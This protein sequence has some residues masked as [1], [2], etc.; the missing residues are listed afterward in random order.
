MLLVHGTIGNP[1][2]KRI[3]GTLTIS[4]HDD[5]FPPVQWPVSDSHF[6]ALIYMM[7]GANRVKFDFSS[8]KLTNSGTSNPLHTSY[9]TIHMVHNSNAPPVHLAIMMGK[10]SPGTFDAVPARIER[11]GNGLET[12]VRKF[13][14]AAYLW[15]AYTTEQ[16][17]RNSFGRRCFRFDEEWTQGTSNYRDREM[18]T[19]RSE[20]RIHIV[21]C[22]K[23]VEELRNL[24]RTGQNGELFGIGIE[25]MKNYFQPKDGQKLYVSCLI[26]DSH[27]DPQ[28]KDILAHAALG[29]GAGDISL[30]IF[31]SHCL[32]SY[33]TSF[34]EVAPAFTDCTPTDLNYVAND[35]N[36]SGSS[37]E[38]C[39][40]GMGA[41]LHETGHMLGLPHRPSG[42]MLRDYVH[43]NRSFVAREAYSTRTKSKGGLVLEADECTWHRLDCIHFR[44]HPCFRLPNDPPLSP[45]NSVQTWSVEGNNVI[46]TAATGI[47]AVEIFAEGDLECNAWVEYGLENGAVQRQVVLSDQV[48]REKLPE[49]KRKSK[50]KVNIKSWGCGNREIEDFKE[51]CAKDS[52]VKFGNKVGFRSYK[53]G[54]SNMEGSQPHEVIFTSASQ[55]GRLL[56]KV[57]VYNGA[58]IDGLKF[59]YDDD[60][61]QLFGKVGGKEGGDTFELGEFACFRGTV[62]ERVLTHFQTSARANTSLASTFVLDSGWMASRS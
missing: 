58:A 61:N 19:M 51:F 36:E 50:M 42:V 25:A 3:D 55:P 37:W 49:D 2:E 56:T 16:M 45:D 34:E 15:Q 6:K 8:P 21:K 57:V 5:A 38:A 48:L 11:E 54:D 41:H 1:S 26:L 53:A 43:F 35:A 17:R 32:Q 60:S 31:G 33:P 12:A 47:A 62:V 22:D 23:T 52:T 10:D 27:W 44:S 46:A 9:L 39:N 7:P 40:I 29:G 18:G 24:N 13:R 14:M 59:V 30:G 20:A 28:A 4:R